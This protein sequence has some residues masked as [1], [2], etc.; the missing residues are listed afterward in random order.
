MIQ[1]LSAFA[2]VGLHNSVDLL[3]YHFTGNDL[4]VY[5]DRLAE[6]KWQSVLKPVI[7]CVYCMASF[8]GTIFYFTFSAIIGQI[9][10]ILWLPS[11]LV[12]A[13][14]IKWIEK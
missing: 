6:S 2:I 5:Y 12:I 13:G 9:D 7:F 3:L 1:L 8:W 11:L 10:F 14:I 4:D